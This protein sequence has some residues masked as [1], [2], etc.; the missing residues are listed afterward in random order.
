MP[1]LEQVEFHTGVA[2]PVEFVGRL[3]GKAYRQGARVLV[4]AGDPV[5]E[6]ISR[7]LW[8]TNERD[9]IA[10]VRLDRC[11]PAQAA[12]APLWLARSVQSLPDE[13]VVVVNAGA[14]AP[15]EVHRLER[16]IEVVGTDPE[17]AELGRQR[18]RQYKAAGLQIKH[19]A[20]R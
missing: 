6:R 16:L 17:E 2:D 12:R 15:P 5:Q 8:T 4:T 3:L 18:W 1:A 7:Y 9:F 20:Q 11:T 13:P 10:H 14:S 19:L